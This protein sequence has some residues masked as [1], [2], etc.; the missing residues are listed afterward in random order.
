[1]G[2]HPTERLFFRRL[3][4]EAGKDYGADEIAMSVPPFLGLQLYC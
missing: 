4:I 2:T 1:M 3:V